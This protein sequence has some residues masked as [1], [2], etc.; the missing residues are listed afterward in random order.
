MY[1]VF[2]SFVTSS[3]FAVRCDQIAVEA[4]SLHYNEICKGKASSPFC[5]EL[6]KDIQNYLTYFYSKDKA[7]CVRIHEKYKIEVLDP[8]DRNPDRIYKPRLGD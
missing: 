2:F 8:I 3:S 7:A 4:M 5:A 6:E 1:F